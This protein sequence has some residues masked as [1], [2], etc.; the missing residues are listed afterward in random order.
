MML[1]FAKKHVSRQGKTSCSRATAGETIVE[2]LVAIVICAFAVVV[3]TT[4]TVAAARLNASAQ[5]RNTSFDEQRAAAESGSASNAVDGTVSIAGKDY[6]A[7]FHG[8]DAVSSYE[9]DSGA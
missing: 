7:L 3:L 8:G 1:L 5:A 2:T 6:S 9:L 4:S